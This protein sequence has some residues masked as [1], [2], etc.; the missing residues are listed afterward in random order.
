MS[1]NKSLIPLA[2][3]AVLYS[4]TACANY[5]DGCND[6][7]YARYMDER[8]ADAQARSKRYYSDSLRNYELSLSLNRNRYQVISELSRHLKYSAQFDPLDIVADKIDRVFAHADM[9][10]REQQIAGDVVDRFSVET[11]SVGIARA[12]V[13]FREGNLEK[14]FA[15]LL[16]SVDRSDSAMMSSFGPDFE[17]VRHIYRQ[18][19]VEPVLAYLEKTEDF[20]KGERPDAL[21]Y[22]WRAMIDAG[23]KVQFDTVDTITVM[24]L[25][26]GV[27]DVN[28]SRDVN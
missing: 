5:P 17:F 4:A 6:A 7:R 3:F 21:R 20:W 8:Y 23:C 15:E 18:G 2:I 13:A 16:A 11:H 1:L 24:E 9:L 26:L 22:V 19:H 10:S 28:R 12:W 25:G 27:R 14:S